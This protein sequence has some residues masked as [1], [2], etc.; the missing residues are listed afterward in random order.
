MI[1]LVFVDYADALEFAVSRGFCVWRNVTGDFWC[2]GPRRFSRAS[3]K[4]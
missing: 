3:R 2:A 4:A 1:G